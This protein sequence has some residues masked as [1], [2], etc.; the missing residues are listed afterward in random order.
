M[1]C[2]LVSKLSI[3]KDRWFPKNIE[4]MCHLSLAPSI[5]MVWNRLYKI[6][7]HLSCFQRRNYMLY[8]QNQHPDSE[9]IVDWMSVSPP[10]SYVCWN[11]TSQYDAIGRWGL[12]EVIRITWHNNKSGALMNRISALIKSHESLLPLSS[13]HHV[14]TQQEV[15]SP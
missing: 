9:S 11:T 15:G 12:W 4:V 8:N 5:M 13:V 7:I 2:C 6:A 3:E 14:K 1:S 10:N